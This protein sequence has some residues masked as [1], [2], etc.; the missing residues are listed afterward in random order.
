MPLSNSDL[1]YQYSG[2]GSNTDPD[3][4]LGGARS[5]NPM[6]NGV[7][8][9]LFRH[10]TGQE[11]NLGKV[12]YRALFIWNAHGSLT[13]I[14]PFLFIATESP[15]PD[16]ETAYG[17]AVEGLGDTIELIPDELTAPTGVVFSRPLSYGTGIALPDI[18]AG[19]AHGIWVR[20]N[21]S[22]NGS[23]FNN[24]GPTFQVTADSEA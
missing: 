17:L 10:G 4:S 23:A 21:I 5:S 12:E 20:R 1:R 16:S 22:S 6:P 13:A 2:G 15:S 8:E 3:A 11:L 14:N 18:P 7:L 24:D 9:N 19:Q